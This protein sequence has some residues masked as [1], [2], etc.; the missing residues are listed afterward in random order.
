MILLLLLL[1]FTIRGEISSIQIVS[2][3]SSFISTSSFDEE[4]NF[5]RII[6]K[7]VLMFIVCFD[8]KRIFS[9]SARSAAISSSSLS[10]SFVKTKHSIGVRFIASSG[11]GSAFACSNNL[12][13]SIRRCCCCR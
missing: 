8:C 5:V 13:H 11:Y 9:I 6:L 2:I 7:K 12:I 10:Y 1:L 3:S 4:L